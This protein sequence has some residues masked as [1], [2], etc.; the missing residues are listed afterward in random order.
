[1]TITV[2]QD[3]N[4]L[5]L[6]ATQELNSVVLQPVLNR[7]SSVFTGNIDGGTATSTYL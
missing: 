6:T 4:Q 2:S 7:L 3:I 1:M 5:T